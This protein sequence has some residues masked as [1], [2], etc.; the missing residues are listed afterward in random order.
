M[1]FAVGRSTGSG[2]TV[3][4]GATRRSSATPEAG[5]HTDTVLAELGYGSEEIA[6]L[7]AG[8]VV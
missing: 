2:L 1:V 5:E 7:R 4:D 8:K 3:P 6:K